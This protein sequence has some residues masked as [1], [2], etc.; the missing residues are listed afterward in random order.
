MSP[1]F[2]IAVRFLLARKRS[3]LMSLA[4]I[5]FGVGF[6][7]VSQAQTSGFEDL[8][9]KTILGTDGAI[10]IEDRIQVTMRSMAAEGTAFAFASRESRKYVSGIDEPRL[11][12]EALAQFPG[13]SGC[14]E[15]IRGNVRLETAT[16]GD[17]GQ[18]FGIRLDDH[19]DVSD[20]DGQIV[21]GDLKEYRASPIAAIV[22]RTLSHRLDITIGDTFYALAEG[23]RR[24]FRVAA[25]F[26]TGVTEIDKVRLYVHLGEARSLFK[27]P[28]GAT[29]MQLNVVD[30]DRAP[31]IAARLEEVL[32]HGVRSWQERER[33]WLGVFKALRISSALTVV[34]IILISGLG[35]FNTLAMIV[36][37][38]TR[39]ISILRSMGYTRQDIS[40]IFL[41]QGGMVLAGG[42]IGGW[43]VGAL[44]TWGLSYVPI[45]IRGIFATSTFVVKWS[46]AHYIVASLTAFI[47]VMTASL[48]PARRA[49]RLEPGDVIRG[50]AT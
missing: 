34:I 14:S 24:Q 22:G 39:E 16:R 25:I 36:M 43:I 47:I 33:V 20:L 44:V 18:V 48:I 37:E 17:S 35:M 29:F 10:R 38:K 50:T 42:T 31:Q 46:L 6:F 27:K 21:L 8:F 2:R 23:Q 45:E 7:V 3:M 12:R 13:I 1:N 4:G 40:R 9:I 28:F 15:V 11:M 49:A 19:L 32:H 41:W 30:R 5:I 26:E